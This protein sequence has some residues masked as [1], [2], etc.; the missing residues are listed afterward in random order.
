MLVVARR[1]NQVIVIDLRDHGLGL[2]K[3]VQCGKRGSDAIGIGVEADTSIPVHRS[4]VFDRI[5]W[6]RKQ[7]DND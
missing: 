1:K 5:E 7:D 2:V 3:I 4:E 6:E